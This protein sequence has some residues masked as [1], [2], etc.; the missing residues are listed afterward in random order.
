MSIMI[1]GE[2]DSK[3]RYIFTK[4]DNRPRFLV[5]NRCNLCPFLIND[6]DNS[7]AKCGKYI[8]S[9]SVWTEKN[10]IMKVHGYIQK[11]AG[12]TDLR[13]L[14]HVDIPEWCELPNHLVQISPNDNI[15]YIKDGKL[16]VESG[17][18]YA[19]TIQIIDGKEVDFGTDGESLILKP[20]KPTYINYGTTPM[21]HKT[22]ETSKINTDVCSFCG[23]D[24][25]NVDR[26][27]HLGMCDDCWDK[28]KF[29]HPKRYS[30]RINNFRLK[31]RKDWV[32]ED[33]KIINLKTT[34][35]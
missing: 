13:I 18:N 4:V 25:E 16:N 14:T 35:V 1:Q 8:N 19:N 28:C 33:F 21:S 26:D 23:E 17:Q 5:I 31:R 15:N 9:N 32:D 24:K 12:S 2:E 20:A 11:K 10:Y 27:N 3:Y 7:S 22:T 29:S 6:S 30:A 34:K